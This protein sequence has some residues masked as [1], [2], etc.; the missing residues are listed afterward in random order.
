MAAQ[1]IQKKLQKIARK[2]ICFKNINKENSHTNSSLFLNLD[3]K[4]PLLFYSQYFY[5]KN[6]LQMPDL[7]II[8][9]TLNE[10]ILNIEKAIS[11][12]HPQINYLIIHQ[13]K[14]AIKTPEFLK[15]E[16]IRIINTLSKGLSKSIN[17]GLKNCKTKYAIIGDDDVEYIEDGIIKILDIIKTSAPDFATFKIKTPN[18]EQDF[19]NYPLKKH[20]FN[21]F[22]IPVAS[23]E[24]LL[25]I[26][27]IKNKRLAFDERFGLG[28]ILKRGEE[29]IFI[30]DLIRNG[31][32]GFFHPIFIVKHPYESTGTLPIKE[33]FRYFLK[34][35]IAERLNLQLNNLNFNSFIRSFKNRIFMLAGRSYILFTKRTKL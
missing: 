13:N 1:T 12:I 14:K 10:R 2:N 29:E 30:Q 3:I 35:A 6:I 19:K 31:L 18:D 22:Y 25:N 26:T 27:K 20:S 5:F 23:I 33:S 15:R 24:I 11:L 16:D 34:G 17:I 7:T 32:M 21:D 9:S 4:K 8:I 28:T